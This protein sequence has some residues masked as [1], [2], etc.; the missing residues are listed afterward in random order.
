MD[1]DPADWTLLSVMGSIRSFAMG[2]PLATVVEDA[3]RW[4]QNR[5]R[6]VEPVTWVSGN[7]LMTT[8]ASPATM[9]RVM[10]CSTSVADVICYLPNQKLPVGPVMAAPGPAQK[11]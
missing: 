8:I 2:R 9:T 10:K 7:V 11:A 3:N 6:S 1:V 5:E 4:N